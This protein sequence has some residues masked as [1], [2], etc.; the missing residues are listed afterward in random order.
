MVGDDDDNNNN[1]EPNI[2]ESTS[3]K[4]KKEILIDWILFCNRKN[5][6]YEF[7]E[8]FCCVCVCMWMIWYD[9]FSTNEPTTTK[10]TKLINGNQCLKFNVI[11]IKMKK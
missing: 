3:K 8:F 1:K 6:D 7:D 9:I 2:Y 4:R 11:I 10:K 5:G